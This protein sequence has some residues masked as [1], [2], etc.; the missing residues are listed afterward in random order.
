M[1]KPCIFLDRD[2]VINFNAPPGDYIRTAGD[3][4]LIPEVAAWIRIFNALEY[5]VIVVTNQRG[6]ALG[7]M[8]EADLA[9]IHRQM[10]DELAQQGARIDDI[11]YCPHEEGSCECRKPRPGMVLEAVRKWDIEVSRS[12]LIGDSDG[13]QQLAAACGLKFIAV[14]NGKVLGSVYP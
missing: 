12:A 2:G 9:A 1:G 7:L 11:F 4:H 13:D 6:I 10:T 14:R 3:F 5:L 8:T